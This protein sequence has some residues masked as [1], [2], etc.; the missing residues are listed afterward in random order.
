MSALP[1]KADIDEPLGASAFFPA[2]VIFLNSNLPDTPRL[3]YV[4][5]FCRAP[6]GFPAMSVPVEVSY[7]SRFLVKFIEIV[8]AGLATAVSG[9]LIAHSHW[10]LILSC[11]D[12]CC[13]SQS[14]ASEHQHAIQFAAAAEPACFLRHQ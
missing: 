13:R 1:P 10:R 5:P 7:F 14:G 2:M 4:A 3:S 6:G 12:P 11:T 9:Y 8:A